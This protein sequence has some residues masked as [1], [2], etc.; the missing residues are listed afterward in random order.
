MQ[1]RRGAERRAACRFWYHSVARIRA[2]HFVLD[3]EGAS[4][5]HLQPCEAP[6]QP[7][8]WASIR[9]GNRPRS[10]QAPP[11]FGYRASFAAAGKRAQ[12]GTVRYG[13]PRHDAG[14][15]IQLSGNEHWG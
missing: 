4:A 5:H 13:P 2:R 11:P 3:R 9:T 15:R 6:K 12:A 1:K 8:A 7:M 14:Q 10:K